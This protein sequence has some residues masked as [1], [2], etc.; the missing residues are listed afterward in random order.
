MADEPQRKRRDWS[1]AIIGLSMGPIILYF[2]HL[3]KQD[4][5]E[6]I[7]VGLATIMVCV[8]IRWDLRK[9]AWFWAVIGALLAAHVPLLFLVHWP[10]GWTPAVVIMPFAAV[11]ALIIL[12]VLHLAANVMGKA[13]TSTE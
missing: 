4:L 8:R 12:G 13:K 2:N 3:G 11:D 7:A 10:K 6:S 9:H 1:G 5:G